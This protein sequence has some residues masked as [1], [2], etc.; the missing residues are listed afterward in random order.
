MPKQADFQRLVTADMGIDRTDH[1]KDAVRI[2]L[3]DVFTLAGTDMPRSTLDIVR[4]SKRYTNARTQLGDSAF[5]GIH[6]SQLFPLVTNRFADKTPVQVVHI[7]QQ[8][9]SEIANAVNHAG[10]YDLLWDSLTFLNKDF[11][12]D[13]VFRDVAPPAIAGI[14]VRVYDHVKKNF[15]YD[16]LTYSSVLTE[17]A[18]ITSVSDILVRHT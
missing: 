13:R 1:S 3:Q 11:S 4:V 10:I 7:L 17:I 9:M 14:A 16:V 18:S 2:L 6:L 12:A 15:K 5:C 8:V